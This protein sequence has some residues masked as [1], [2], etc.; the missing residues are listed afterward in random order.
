MLKRLKLRV[1]QQ[2]DCDQ[3]NESPSGRKLFLANIRPGDQLFGKQKTII[4]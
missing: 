2:I 4:I 3:G 1:V